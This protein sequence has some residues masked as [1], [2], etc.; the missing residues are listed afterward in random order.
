MST[1]GDYAAFHGNAREVAQALVNLQF[2]TGATDPLG[3]ELREG[4]TDW[5]ARLIPFLSAQGFTI[6]LTLYLYT[7]A[8]IV[9]VSKRLPRPWPEIA[10]LRMPRGIGLALIVGF[11]LAA[12]FGSS[13]VGVFGMALLGALFTAFSIQ[14]LAIIHE[15]TKGRA[16][17]PMILTGLYV[18]LFITQ[19][20][21]MIALSLLGLADTVFGSRRSAGSPNPPPTPSSS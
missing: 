14:G 11:A 9:F 12:L 20:A 5:I 10:R 6:A 21:L 4:V 18:L 1:G 17:R 19:G 8:K 2:P 15:R 3:P 16:F 7:A 13:F